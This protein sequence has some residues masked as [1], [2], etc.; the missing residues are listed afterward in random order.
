MFLK[1]DDLWPLLFNFVVENA[2]RNVQ[3]N[4]EKLQ[5]NGTCSFWYKL[6]TFS[7]QKHIYY[8]EENRSLICH[9]QG[10]WSKSKCINYEVLYRQV[11]FYA[12]VTFLKKS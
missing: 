11:S 5:L 7:G 3:A 2:H 6:M 9:L 4:K 12:Q 10:H 8:E 1:K